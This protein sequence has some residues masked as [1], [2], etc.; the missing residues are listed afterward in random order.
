M[1][2][3]EDYD[4]EEDTG[5]DDYEP[6]GNAT[7]DRFAAEAREAGW[8]V[9]KYQGRFWY[10]GPAVVTDDESTDRDLQAA[11]RATTVRVQWDNLGLN[12]VVYPK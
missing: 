12:Y 7:H 2:D 10:D 11:I 9:C 3:E 6:T 5:R 8:N 1:H 4:D